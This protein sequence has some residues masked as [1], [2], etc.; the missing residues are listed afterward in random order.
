MTLLVNLS[1]LASSCL[2][3]GTGRYP[4]IDHII[5]GYDHRFGKN[6]TGGLEELQTYAESEAYTVEEIT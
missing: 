2:S 1:S 5:I 6:R 4:S 3:R